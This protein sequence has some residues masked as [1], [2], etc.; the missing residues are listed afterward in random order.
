LRSPHLALLALGLFACVD[1]E[2]DTGGDATHGTHHATTSATTSTAT[3]STTTST[4]PTSGGAQDSDG[5]GLTDDL[6]ASLGT[7]P[8]NADTDGD[9]ISDSDELMLGTDPVATDSDGDG[10]SDGDELSVHGT[11]PTTTDSDGDGLSDGEEIAAGSDP[12]DWDTDGDQVSDGAEVEEGADPLTADTDRDGLSDD[13]EAKL[14]TDPAL[15]DTDSDGLDDADEVTSGTDPLDEDSDDDLL[16]D[17]DEVEAGTDPLSADTDGDGF[18]DGEEVGSL[19]SDPLDATSPVTH[20]YK[21]YEGSHTYL[22]GRSTDPDELDCDLTWSVSGTPVNPMSTSCP[23][24]TFT[25]N[26]EYGEPTG[27]GVGGRFCEHYIDYYPTQINISFVPDFY[28]YGP[29]WLAAVYGTYYY[30]GPA[31]LTTMPDKSLEL[32]YRNQGAVAYEVGGYYYTDYDY[33]SAT[34]R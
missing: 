30:M 22:S 7:D 5:D 31:E 23:D 17:G 2:D 33:G 9:G 28:G 24:C 15:T 19:G 16:S 20:P 14:G 27:T 11:D 32:R 21:T 13:E 4:T 3:T 34:I 29:A 1:K 6:E 10:L 26:V 12:R 8:D 25:F 18:S